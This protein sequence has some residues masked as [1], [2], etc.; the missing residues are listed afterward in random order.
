MLNNV[1]NPFESKKTENL[2]ATLIYKI[3]PYW[4]VFAFAI[5][6][7]F[8]VSWVYLKMK[9]PIYDSSAQ[10]LLKDNKS[11]NVETKFLEEMVSMD[12]NKVIENEVE[13]IK[14]NK[15]LNQVVLDLRLYSLTFFEGKFR[16]IPAHNQ[17][18][19]IVENSNPESIID[20]K[21]KFF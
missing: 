9:T 21:E 19:L 13:I 18:S 3:V 5:L 6:I 17:F 20:S 15:V 11:E 16:D 10:I 14:S 7:S 8:V 1:N 2:L 4:N 12:L